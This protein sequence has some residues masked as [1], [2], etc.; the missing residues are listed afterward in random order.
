MEV[1]IT[2]RVHNWKDKDS[3]IKMIH[4]YD[5]WFVVL[6]TEA[7]RDHIQG[8]VKKVCK[9]KINPK[10]VVDNFRIKLKKNQELEG[11]KDF[12]V[13]QN[14]GNEK[15]IV[16]LCKGKGRSVGPEVVMNNILLEEDV[17][18]SHLKY[19]EKNEELKRTDGKKKWYKIKEQKLSE[20][21]QK[22]V[23]NNQWVEWYMKIIL[24]H[25]S[26]DL[27]IPDQYQIEKL[28]NTY[29][30]KSV[31]DK[32]LRAYHMGLKAFDSRK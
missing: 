32:E 27:I 20:K 8:V 11:N 2:F 9:N 1:W 17:R 6:E 7:N 15:N 26:N 10:S 31:D 16:Y 19:W 29:M 4:G 22:K 24:Y 18:L 25:D 30:F 28:I 23:E 5:K 12:S 14:D 21:W 3:L 13:K